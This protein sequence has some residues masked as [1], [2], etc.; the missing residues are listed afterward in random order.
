M[1]QL[2]ERRLISGVALLSS[3]VI[4]PHVSAINVV[5]D[6]TYDTGNFFGSGNPQGATA[7][8]EARATMEFAADFFSDILADSFTAIETPPT[9]Y[10]QTFDGSVSWSWNLNFSNPYDNSTVTLYDQVIPEDEYRVYVGARNIPG[11][12]IGFGG[13]GGWGWSST[14]SGGFTQSE[15]SQIEQISDDFAASIE[16]GETSGFANWGGAV[17]FDTTAGWHYDHT[18]L[19]GFNESDFLTTV[20]HELAHAFGFGVSTE[21]NSWVSGGYFTG[22]KSVAENG[23]IV[24]VVGGH[25]ASSVNSVVLGTTTPQ[26]ANLQATS[27]R[28][29]RQLLTAI[30]AAS[31]EDIGWEIQVPI[32]YAEAD[33]DTD[34][35][36]DASDLATLE[37]WYGPYTNG[38]AD[39]DGDTDGADY[40]IWQQQ[41][42]GT[43]TPLVA[44]VPEPTTLSLVGFFVCLGLHRR[45]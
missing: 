18:T 27:L 5:I 15:I 31:L 43:I 40:L 32:A 2:R 29:T 39:D 20:I 21:W 17:T 44:E 35:D 10:S 3:L 33:F 7:G 1:L 36:V 41:Y 11:S 6:Y 34:G 42:T 16:R 26:E 19:P 12:T 38:D 13:P 4:A 8:A 23:G 14:P 28:G 45:R 30:D 25:W 37:A 24:P 22:P 9:F